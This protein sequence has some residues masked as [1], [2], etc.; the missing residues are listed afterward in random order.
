LV[1]LLADSATLGR[2]I[3]WLKRLRRSVKPLHFEDQAMVG[4]FDAAIGL[5]AD[6]RKYF[7]TRT[8]FLWMPGG[9]DPSRAAGVAAGVDEPSGR[10]RF[11]YSG[12]LGPHAG[13]LEMAKVFAESGLDNQLRICGYGKQS[14]EFAALAASCPRVSFHGFLPGADACLHFAQTCDALVNPR[15]ASHGNENNF[16]SKLF[17]YALGGRA[18]LTSRMSGVDEVVGP[19][20]FYF[21]ARDFGPSLHRAMSEIAGLPREVLWR[22]GQAIRERVAREYSWSRQAAKIAEFLNSR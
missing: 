8:P 17:E 15:P 9:C 6:T 21:D 22:R 12:S 16:P 20:G 2:K 14:A 18:I 10:A 1:L 5:S 7:S 19:E 4:F 11:G 13:A 3:P